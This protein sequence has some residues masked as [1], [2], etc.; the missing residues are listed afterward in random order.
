MPPEWKVGWQTGR[1]Q[2]CY[3]SS[4]C[5][6]LKKEKE[7]N[8]LWDADAKWKDSS[9]NNFYM[10]GKITCDCDDVDVF[11]GTHMVV[12]LQSISIQF[13]QLKYW[14]NSSH[15]RIQ[16]T[17]TFNFLST[18]FNICLQGN[19]RSFCNSKLWNNSRSF[20]D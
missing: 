11:T 19:S 10:F 20:C 16:F 12:S 14:D 13:I 1:R 18:K 4:S 2:A 6:Q 5:S 7:A 15:D 17:C 8:I 9:L 3:V